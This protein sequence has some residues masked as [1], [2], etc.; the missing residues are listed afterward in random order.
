[1][2]NGF[3]VLR[4][5]Q[6]GRKHLAQAAAGFQEAAT[7]EDERCPRRGETRET[8][9]HRFRERVCRVR[10]P[11][12]GLVSDVRRIADIHGEAHFFR[13]SNFKEICVQQPTRA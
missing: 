8:H 3:R 4:V 7:V 6:L 12:P 9:A 2:N 5:K 1:M 11:V 13:G 10:A